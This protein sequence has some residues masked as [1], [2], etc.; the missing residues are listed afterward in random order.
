MWGYRRLESAWLVS[1]LMCWEGA[2]SGEGMGSLHPPPPCFALCIFP[3][4]LFLSRVLCNQLIIANSVFLPE[5]R[6][7]FQ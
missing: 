7:L 1:M 4:W 5:F 6:E 2:G 3:S